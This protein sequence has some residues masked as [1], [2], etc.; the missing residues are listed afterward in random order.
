MLFE[1][2]STPEK[3]IT[4]T[5]PSGKKVTVSFS[6]GEPTG[7]E[8]LGYLNSGIKVPD[9]TDWLEYPV[10]MHLD[11]YLSPSLKVWYA[12]DSSG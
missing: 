7:Y 12:V 1:T 10:R 8:Y 9:A 4:W 2:Y 11:Y 6:Q 3:D 5:Y